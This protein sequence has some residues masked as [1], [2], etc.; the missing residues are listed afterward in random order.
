MGWIKLGM[1]VWGSVTTILAIIILG[2]IAFASQHFGAD[3]KF[4]AGAPQWLIG[5]YSAIKD[6]GPLLA[7]ILTVSGLAW[8]YFFNQAH[9]NDAQPKGAGAKP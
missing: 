2:S 4:V 8:S 5:A 3:G 1:W 7:A 6:N 9:P